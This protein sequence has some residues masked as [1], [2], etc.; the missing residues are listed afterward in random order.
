M[1]GV[2]RTVKSHVDHRAAAWLLSSHPFYPIFPMGKC[3]HSSSARR[4]RKAEDS[5]CKEV[6]DEEEL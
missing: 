3:S 6:L 4:M 1:E 2:L 5:L